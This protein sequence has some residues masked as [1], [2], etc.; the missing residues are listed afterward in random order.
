MNSKIRDILLFSII[1][2]IIFNDIPEVLRINFMGGILQ[3]K[4]VFYPILVGIIYTIYCQYKYKN[5]LVN[6]RSFFKYILLYMGIIFVSLIVGLYK[7]PYY[8]EILNGPIDQIEKLPI[9]LNFFRN[10]NINFDENILLIIWMIFRTIK[11]FALEIIYTFCV[12]YMIYCWYYDNWKRAVKILYYAT[13]SAIVIIFTYSFIEILYLA[14][15][16]VAINILECITPYY[17]AVEIYYNWWPPLLWKG[18]LRSMFAEPSYLGIYSAF[19]MPFLWYKIYTNIKNKYIWLYSIVI[20]I[21]TVCLFLT[22]AR[23]GIALFCGELTLLIFYFI[24][25]HKKMLM[26]KTCIII[27]ITI[28][29]FLSANFFISDFEKNISKEDVGVEAYI[30]NNLASMTEV[31]KRSNNARYSVII[32]N[33][34]IGIDNCILG[35]GLNLRNAYIPYYLPEFSQNSKE[36]QMWID[37]QK[38]K[39]I[40]KSGFPSLCEYS[41]RFAETGFI[42]LIVFCYPFV[43]LLFSLLK[44]IRR[45]DYSLDEKIFYGC[46]TIALCGV[47]M[48]GFS[49]SLTILYCYW[50]LLAIGYAM[51]YGKN[52]G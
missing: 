19:I 8:N 35:V 2:S 51:C 31:E 9:V 46:F 37:E 7:Y 50:I 45:K 42:G 29:S 39:G 17:H 34:K 14:G 30:E 27:F 47:L 40:L 16:D 3:S 23:T 4:L 13:L 12:T 1:F 44:K 11:S 5:I 26:K 6:Q 22:K 43:I 41:T 10:N 25:L 33:T 24:Y 15:N 32:A 18:Q 20:F 52:E 48:A 28:F 36:V 21:F 38:E 49:N